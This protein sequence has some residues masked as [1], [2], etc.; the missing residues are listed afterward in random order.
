MH[1]QAALADD[2]V[3]VDACTQ[4]GNGTGFYIPVAMSAIVGVGSFCET[5]V[6]VTGIYGKFVAR[7]GLCAM[8]T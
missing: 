8:G 4:H 1:R 3:F 5:M 7:L 6:V 2:V